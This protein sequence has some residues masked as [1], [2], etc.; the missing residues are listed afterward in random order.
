MSM[1]VLFLL[2]ILWTTST[3]SIIHIHEELRANTLLI[4]SISSSPH[5]QWFPLE[6]LTFCWKVFGLSSHLLRLFIRPNLDINDHSPTFNQSILRLSLAENLPIGYEIPL[7]PAVDDD[8]GLL[9]IQNYQLYP[10]LNNP[11]RLVFNAKPILQ[12]TELLDREMKSI[13][14]LTLI[15]YDG[16]EPALS[17][18]QSIE[19]LLT[20]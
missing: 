2:L 16:G 12:L 18:E 15:A 17:G 1:F 11:F 14:R 20:K 4:S 9:S 5:V 6:R 10:M 7:P 19:I 3:A 13:Y 8:D